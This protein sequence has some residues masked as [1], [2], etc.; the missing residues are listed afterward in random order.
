MTGYDVTDVVPL[1]SA[2][3]T[4]FTELAAN[5]IDGTDCKFRIAIAFRYSSWGSHLAKVLRGLGY[6]IDL[7]DTTYYNILPLVATYRA[8]WDIFGLEQWQNYESTYASRLQSLYE[9]VNEPKMSDPEFV[10]VFNNFIRNELGAMWVTEK[11]DYISAHLP[12]PT[13][14]TANEQ[15]NASSLPI[16]DVVDIHSNTGINST[17]TNTMQTPGQPSNALAW[18]QNQRYH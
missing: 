14:A 1:G 5:V 18:S 10:G 2:D 16:V 13:I 17:D 7:D 4:L 11:K 3:Y 12:Q 15:L 9:T 8:Y 6:P